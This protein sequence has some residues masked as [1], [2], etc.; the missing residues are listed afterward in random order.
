MPDPDPIAWRDLAREHRIDPDEVRLV[1]ARYDA[2]RQFHARSRGDPIALGQWFRFYRMEKSTE[3]SQAGPAASGC[4]VDSDAVN[5]ACIERPVEFL[6][7]LEAYAAV[8]AT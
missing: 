5:D 3:G 7:V 6:A 2:Q 1:F 8:E 4:S